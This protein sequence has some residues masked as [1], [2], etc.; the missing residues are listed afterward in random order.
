M[1]ARQRRRW[2][3]AGERFITRIVDALRP[4]EAKITADPEGARSD[5]RQI[6]SG[7][8]ELFKQPPRGN[9]PE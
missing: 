2:R 4:L 6:I 7:V 1:N 8:D 3:R 9:S 5:F